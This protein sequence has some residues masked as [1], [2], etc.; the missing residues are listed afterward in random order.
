MQREIDKYEENR[1][2]INVD[3]KIRAWQEAWFLCSQVLNQ[4]SMVNKISDYHLIL[5]QWIPLINRAHN[6]PISLLNK[7]ETSF[8]MLNKPSNLQEIFLV[9]FD[10]QGDQPHMYII[11]NCHL[12]STLHK[13]I[14]DIYSKNNEMNVDLDRGTVNLIAACNMQI[15]PAEHFKLNMAW[16]LLFIAVNHMMAHLECF[17]KL[18]TQSYSD[19]SQLRKSSFYKM[20]IYGRVK[21]RFTNI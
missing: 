21:N 9:L 17:E 7:Y 6:H 12:F 14:C 1:S 11:F 13:L 16:Y 3:I 8:Y 19:H 2:P 5:E 20:Y 4:Y 15:H 18:D 10:I